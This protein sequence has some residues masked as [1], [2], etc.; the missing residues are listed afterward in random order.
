MQD[1]M[2]IGLMGIMQIMLAFVP[3]L[4]VY[5]Y[6]VGE[7]YLGILNLIAVY[8]ILGIG[9]DDIF[10]FADQ[11]YHQREEKQFDL[12]MQ[13]TYNLAG[14]AIFTTSCTTFISFISNAGSA[15]PAVA[16]FGLF[17]ALLVAMN[18]LAVVT[19][20]P[21][22]MAVYHT[23]IRQV[24]WDHPSL[25]FCCNR[26]VPGMQEE[27]EAGVESEGDE[28]DETNDGEHKTGGHSGDESSLVAFFRDR[29]APLIIRLRYPIVI[30]YGAVFIAAMYGA[31]QLEPDEEAPSTLPDGNNYKE[32][33]QVCILYIL[34]SRRLFSHF[35]A[36]LT[37]PHTNSPFN[38]NTTYRFFSSTLRE[39]EIL[40]RSRFD[41]SL[42][43]TLTTP[44]TAVVRMTR[45][46]RITASQISSTAA[47][48][49]RVPQRRRSG[50]CKAAMTCSSETSRTIIMATLASARM[51]ST[52]LNPDWL[53]PRLF[54]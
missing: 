26:T 1:S 33:P 28:G 53:Y 25:L 3:T 37:H 49:I 27:V 38:L 47:L 14:K 4:L 36:L 23:R 54:P 20:F 6:V 16:T 32:Y 2:F 44:L 21:A 12:R 50:P 8:I 48:L 45:I 10:V 40:E 15:F 30:F 17:A 11:F 35:A 22:V 46:L 9:V 41:G 24:W 39:L 42:E 31:A 18:Y 13:K 51:V 5:R 7:D 43:L 19:F 52:D 34:A 29:W